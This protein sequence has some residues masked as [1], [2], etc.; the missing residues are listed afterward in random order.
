MSNVIQLE[1]FEAPLR[2]RRIR[3]LLAPGAPIAYP[4]GFQ[5]QAFIEPQ[6]FQRRVLLT[7]HQS[8]EA[9][10]LVDKWD[11]VLTPATGADWSLV[12]TVVLNTTQ[13]VLVVITPECRTPPAF[14]QR[15]AQIPV[16]KAPTFVCFQHLTNPPPTPPVTMDATFFPPSKV[17]EDTTL[18][19]TQIVLQQLC[20]SDTLH[21]FTLKDALRDLRG[22]GAT[23][24]VSSIGDDQPTMYWY[25]ATEAQTKGNTLLSS[26]IQTLL[27]RH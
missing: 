20:S 26:V 15:C 10:K 3:W 2:G 23:L 27:V 11:T 8:S 21:N 6:P 4:P 5:E 9:W 17:L 16:Q 18:E 7:S 24:V 12:L 1:A 25:Y 22:A 14:F 19:A 13:P